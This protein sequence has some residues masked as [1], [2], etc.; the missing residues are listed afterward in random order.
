MFIKA[1]KDTQKFPSDHQ[2]IPVCDL[3]HDQGKKRELMKNISRPFLYTAIG[4]SPSWTHAVAYW[5]LSKRISC[6]GG[7]PSHLNSQDSFL[8]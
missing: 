3:L 8:I 7:Q 1:K 2:L 6:A 5:A 4:L